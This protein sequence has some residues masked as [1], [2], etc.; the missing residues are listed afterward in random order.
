MVEE[1]ETGMVNIDRISTKD[2]IKEIN[3]LS[4]CRP[5]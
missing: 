4:M 3:F 1:A 5:P 2:T